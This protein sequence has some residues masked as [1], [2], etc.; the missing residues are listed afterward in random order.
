[1][2]GCQLNISH[3][4]KSK[5]YDSR[6]KDI[7]FIIIHY[8]ETKTLSHAVDL[9][10]C[11]NR[12][13]SCHYLIDIDGRVYNLVDEKYRAWHAGDSRWMKSSD[14]NSRSIGIEIVNEGEKK[15][16]PFKKK[17]IRKLVTLVKYLKSKYKIFDSKILGHSDI[18]PLRKIDPGIQF[19]W[20]ILHENSLGL[21]AKDRNDNSKL[22]DRD[23]KIFIKNLRKIGYSYLK[24]FNKQDNKLIIDAFHRHHLPKRLN[25]PLNRSSLNKSLDLLKIKNY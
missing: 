24:N 21:W 25:K 4:F 2:S 19:P 15:K 13:V 7:N 3:K 10:T 23:Y 6:E 17:Q 9:L 14:I 12:K 16:S 11:R 1:M 8:T 18:A 22:I 20:Q 5:N